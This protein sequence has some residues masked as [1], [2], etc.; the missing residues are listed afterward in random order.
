MLE[1]QDQRRRERRFAA[2]F[3]VAIA[4]GL[5]FA[6]WSGWTGARDSGSWIRGYWSYIVALGYLGLAP[7]VLAGWFPARQVLPRGPRP[8]RLD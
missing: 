7:V 2:M 1:E 8:L 6:L 4:L 5:P 3:L